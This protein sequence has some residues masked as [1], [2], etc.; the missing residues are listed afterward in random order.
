MRIL[1]TNDDG[2]NSEGLDA[3][4]EALSEVDSAEGKAHELIVVA[5]DGE[6]SGISNAMTLKLPTKLRKISENRYSCSGTPVDCVIVAGLNVLK[7]R[8]DLVISGINR[9][10]NLG[11]DII[12]SGTCGAARQAALSGV[13]AIAVSCASLVP[14]FEY[15]ACAS[16]V[17]SNLEALKSA[18]MPGCFVNINGPSS[19]DPGL[20]AKWTIPGRNHYFDN[21]KCF[22][23]EDNYTYC[24]LSD[25]KHEREKEGSADHQAVAEGFIAISLV[26]IHPASAHP[27]EWNGRLFGQTGIVSSSRVETGP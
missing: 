20:K 27:Q 12:Y 6:R 4:V 19:S 1:L 24:F 7:N 5:P 23:G 21:I 26:D 18:W 13:P 15:G 16:F 10:P 8:P 17:A 11:T 2:I 9:G 14:P 25:G 3:L 22:D